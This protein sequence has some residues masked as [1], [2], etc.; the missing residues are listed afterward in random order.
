[1]ERQPLQLVERAW[2]AM[3]GHAYDGLP[4][5]ACGL[6]GGSPGLDRVDAFVPCR[7]ADASSRT[8]SIGPDGWEA[9][10][11]VFGPAGLDVVGVI[12][13]HTHTDAY[14]SPTDVAKADNP[15]LAG[16]HY[17]ILSLK[18]P[19][20]VLRSFRIEDGNIAEEPVVLIGQ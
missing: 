8:Y 12:H 10:D 15:L 18:D 4:D 5:E 17:L 2:L 9:A 13:S 6:L 16:W 3:V 14:P 19:E 7:N 11:E 20:P 1:V